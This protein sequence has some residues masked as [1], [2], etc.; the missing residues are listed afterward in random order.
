MEMGQKWNLCIVM[1]CPLSDN[2]GYQNR[3]VQITW[4]Y[5]YWYVQKLNQTENGNEADFYF[6]F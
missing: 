1:H 6:F 2:M 3:Y 5:K 4:M